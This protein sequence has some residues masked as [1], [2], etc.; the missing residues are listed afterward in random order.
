MSTLSPSFEKNPDLD[1]WL[2]VRAEG[3]LS[4][5]PG[6]AELGQGI[7]TALAMIAAEELDI[8]ISRIDIEAVNTRTSPNESYTAGSMSMEHSGQ[9][10]RQAAAEAR[11]IMIEAAAGQFNSSID[12]LQVVDGE[13]RQIQGKKRIS[14]WELFGNKKFGVT[15]TGQAPL[16]S[17][18]QYQIV[19]KKVEALDIRKLV[20]G[21]SRYLHDLELPGMVHGRVVRPPNYHAQLESSDLAS[22]ESMPGVLKVVIDGRFLAVIA[23]REE[24]AINAASRIEKSSVWKNTRELPSGDLLT[25]LTNNDRISRRVVDGIPNQEPVAAPETAT[26]S[27]KSISARYFRP[28]QMHASMAPSAS[29]AEYKNGLLSVFTHSQGV[30]PL[31]DA[32]ADVLDMDTESVVVT[33]VP[34][35]GCYGHNGA[36]DAGLDAALLARALPDRPVLLKWQRE[37]EHCW[38]PYG[39]AM[40]VDISADLDPT[41]KVL[42]WNHDSYSDTH[43]GRPS[44]LGKEKSRLLAAWHLQNPM[45]KPDPQPS[46]LYHAGIHRNA[47]PI[48]RFPSQN[49]TKHLV[50]DL[51]LRVSSLRSLGRLCECLCDRIVH[52]RTRRRDKDGSIDISTHTP[53]RF[54]CQTG[55]N[56]GGGIRNMAATINHRRLGP[57]ARVRPL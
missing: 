40:V 45:P 27:V 19:G 50:R 20:T 51:P 26:G 49:I 32:I 12:E 21:A 43:M 47:D 17:A 53:G 2:A 16:K 34:G 31:R 46:M 23:Q 18:D 55:A 35:A 25:L 9:A 5:F 54:A 14:Y 6:K 15:V 44:G 42:A 30:Y 13:I 24:Q 38:E 39:S 4:V 22:V 11:R 37:D 3:R 36:D 1:Q 7:K 29:L 33:H 41:G 56:H 8:D 57:R 28:Y 52:G 10:I 48:Y